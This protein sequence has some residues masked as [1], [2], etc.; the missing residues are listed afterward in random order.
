MK[1][2]YIGC[3]GQLWSSHHAQVGS[4]AAEPIQNRLTIS[5]S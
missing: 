5:G 4:R 1:E 2:A 3:L